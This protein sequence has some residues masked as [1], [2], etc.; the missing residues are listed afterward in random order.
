MNAEL[1]SI[2]EAANTISREAFTEVNRLPFDIYMN[3]FHIYFT[4][5][6]SA[7]DNSKLFAKWFT[8]AGDPYRPVDLIDGSGI[9]VERV[10]PVYTNAL[11][12]RESSPDYDQAAIQAGL[13]NDHIPNS[14]EHILHK[15]LKHDIPTIQNS[16]RSEFE[17]FLDYFTRKYFNRAVEEAK[18]SFDVDDELEL[19]L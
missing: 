15:T 7:G 16:M 11:A 12:M 6:K 2:K 19:D 18:G 4:G 13:H 1:E 5:M 10:P 14:G 9:V 3:M 17:A 8:I